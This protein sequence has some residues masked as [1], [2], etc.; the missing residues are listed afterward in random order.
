MNEIKIKEINI[1]ESANALNEN[2]NSTSQNN[3]N[4]VDSGKGLKDK[5]Q[6]NF[7]LQKS[8]FEEETK[9]I[10]LLENNSD[11]S[12]KVKNYEN[13]SFNIKQ[14]NY[15]YDKKERNKLERKMKNDLNNMYK[16]IKMEK[17]FLK[18]NNSSNNNTNKNTI[19][20]NKKN[21]NEINKNRNFLLKKLIIIQIPLLFLVI[22]NIIL[23]KILNYRN[24]LNNLNLYISSLSISCALSCFNLFLIVL[25]ILG[26][27][28][29]Y[30]TSNLFRFLC[31]INFC[32]S[33]SLIIIQI[34][35]ISNIKSN[36]N[37]ELEKKITKIFI[38]FLI[39]MITCLIL[40][41][42]IFIGIIAKESLL[43]IGGWKNENS[44]PERIVKKSSNKVKG[45]YVYFDEELYNNE[46]NIKALKKFH[47]CIYS[48][49]K[50]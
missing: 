20:F 48:N 17:K 50:S 47:A 7:S 25:I 32:I 41:I 49:E 46:T 24:N 27:F 26:I 34:I 3:Q 12:L 29:H 33:I 42:N 37:F 35:L 43:I 4:S 11:S 28:N 22:L 6:I 8:S 15:D 39:F 44:C 38:Y 13:I 23:Y 31:I 18:N 21:I 14:N 45:N 16:E 2:E 1:K 19:N 30:Y 40:L 10:T 9:N 36:I 5:S